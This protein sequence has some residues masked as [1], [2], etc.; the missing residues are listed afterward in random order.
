MSTYKGSGYVYGSNLA[1][2]LYGDVSSDTLYGGAGA[3]VMYGG[4]GDDTYYVDN[5]KD[6]VVEGLNGGNDTVISSISYSLG[7]NVENL[8]LYGVTNINATGNALS[9]SLVGNIG[10][11]ILNGGLGADTMSGGKGNDTYYVDNS[12]DVV[13]ENYGEGIDTVIS[14][15]NYTMDANV[16]ILTLTGAA[17]SA[18]GNELDNTIT[19]NASANTLSGGAGNDIL[20]GA[21]GA[22]IMYGGAGNDT[23]YVDNAGDQ[24]KENSGEGVD[25]VISAINYTIGANV[26]N[27]VLSAKAVIG[28]GNDSN[29][30]ITGTASNNILDGGAGNDNLIGGAGNDIYYVDSSSDVVVETLNAGIDTVYS[31]VNYSLGANVE[32]LTL[33]GGALNGFGNEVNNSITGN[34]NDN[35]LSGGAGNDTLDGS[36]GA[37]TMNGGV[38]NDTYYVDNSSDVVI[39]GLDEGIDS[40]Y[41]SVDYTLSSNVEN[42]ALAGASNTNA[43]GNELSNTLVGN[44]GNNI[45]NGGAGNDVLSGGLGADT[46]I[47][48]VGDDIYYVESSYDV[49]SEEFDEGFDTVISAVNYNLGSNVENLMLTGTAITATGNEL[50]NIITGNA[51]A[52]TIYAG[53]GNDIIIAGAGAD[54][55]YGGTGNDTYYVDSSADGIYENA[56]EGTDTVMSVINYSIGANVEN[57]ILSGKALIGVGNE[58]NNTITGNAYNNTLD[59]MSGSDTMAGGAGNDVYYVDNSNDVAKEDLNA[60]TDT[61]LASVNYTIGA[62]IE[63]L[64]LTGTADI[65]GTG[66]ELGNVITG[67]AGVNILSGAAGN[68]I[69]IGGA[70]AD[71]MIGGIGDDTYYVDNSADVLT[72]GLNEGLDTVYSSVSYVLSS[73]IENLVLSGTGSIN[74]TGNEVNNKLYGTAG[75]NII[76]GGAGADTMIGGAGNDTYVIDNTGDSIVEAAKNGGDDTVVSKLTSYTLGAYVERLVIDNSIINQDFTGTG[77]ALNNWITGGNGNDTLNGGAGADTMIGGSGNDT[78]Y[79]DNIADSI[80]EVAGQGTDKVFSTI[81]YVLSANVENLTL[82]GTANINGTGN[83]SDNVITGNSGAN[84]LNGGAGNDVLDGGLGLD[85]L[86]GGTGNDTY[87]VESTIDKLFE[88]A[89]EGIDTVVAKSS[90]TLGANLDNLTL[91][92]ST[93]I[94]TATTY[95][96]TQ[97]SVFGESAL[98]KNYLD[99][100]QGDN[101]YGYLGDCGLVACENILI[102]A[103]VF[104]KKATYAPGN[105]IIDQ[106]ETT[107]VGLAASKGWC[108]N[109]GAA[110]SKGGT[111]VYNQE[112]VLEYYGVQATP[113]LV[114]LENLAQFIKDDKCV[115]TEINAYKIWGA[116]Y[117]SS[118]TINHAITLTGV[119]YNAN[120]PSKIEGFY[121]CDSGRRMTSDAERFVTYDMMKSAFYYFN[122]GTLGYAVVSDSG[123]KQKLAS[124]DGTGNTLDNV[125][126]GSDGNNVLTGLSGNDTYVVNQGGGRDVI[127]DSSGANDILS[128]ASG[129]LKGDIAMFASGNDLILDYKN[130]NQVT[131]QDQLSGADAVEKVQLSDNSYVSNGIINNLIQQMASYASSHGIQITSGDVVRGDSYLSNLVVNSWQTA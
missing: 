123:V 24:V 94:N 1:D 112:S 6:A 18:V 80:N 22:D 122:G 44:A 34:G 116:Q 89:N 127:V 31:S 12:G 49:V 105:G 4:S 65:N 114:S 77:N 52:N 23:Y 102:Q 33:T 93:S 54:K 72:E 104:D 28:V 95:Y 62:N 126:T 125:I 117:G 10:N 57:L 124:M 108:N 39:E 58:S 88:N 97:V 70:G 20:N 92:G 8:T 81:S 11:N 129:I 100:Y 98:W 103:G 59:G 53:A 131:I 14:S 48:G 7:A 68:D 5:A 130:G 27:L 118:S 66:N 43:T 109:Y 91:V 36:L 67:N 64:V 29:N 56:G 75:N 47:G 26:E 50:D 115:I 85:S 55:M 16:E 84:I 79:V 30:T 113:Q 15:V 3:D 35:S 42:L 38:G 87:Y 61:V 25:T 90:Y 17:V 73:N 76:D 69:L 107:V 46:M 71:T 60:G 119:A 120:D 86:Y 128:F 111:T 32:N 41:S 101:S 9:N 21:T 110:G 74:A 40:V 63:N 99:Y 78:Y 82:S 2:V 19:G 96:G 83:A 37:D 45:L 106:L 51:Y 13:R 121:V